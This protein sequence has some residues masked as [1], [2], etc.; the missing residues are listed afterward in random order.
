MRHT[1]LGKVI[2]TTTILPIDSHDLLADK[3]RTSIDPGTKCT[4]SGDPMMGEL[5]LP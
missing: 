2:R 4:W 5:L 3:N 1:L